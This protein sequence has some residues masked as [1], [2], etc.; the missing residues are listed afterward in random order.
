MTGRSAELGNAP[1][2]FRQQLKGRVCRQTSIQIDRPGHEIVLR[3]VQPTKRED[4]LAPYLQSLA[5]GGHD[6]DAGRDA[7][8]LGQEP[9]LG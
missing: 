7:H 2:S 8:D 1:D 9:D 3:V 6:L 5:G 4:V